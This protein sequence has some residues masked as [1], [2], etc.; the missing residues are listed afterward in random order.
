MTLRAYVNGSGT[1]RLTAAAILAENSVEVDVFERNEEVGGAAATARAFD[2]EDLIDLGAAAHPIAFGSMAFR[3]LD[4]K[5]H[6]LAWNFHDIPLAHPLDDAPSAFLHNTLAATTAEFA[7]DRKI[8][9]AL[10]HPFRKRAQ[11]L[12]DNVTGP[13]LRIPR[14]RC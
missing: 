10:Y 3:H 4:L 7:Q 2:G 13:M 1:K 6:G 14:N 9:T 8:W 11:Q 12:L 5:G